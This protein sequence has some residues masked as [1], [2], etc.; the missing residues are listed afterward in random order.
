MKVSLCFD[1][2]GID[3]VR[4]ADVFRR[5]PLGIRDPEK[6][7]RAFEN[8][9]TVCFAFHKDR[10]MGMARALSDGEYHAAVY[11]LVVLPEYQG[12]GIGRKIVAAL[13][14]RLPVRTTILYAVPGKE[15]FYRKLGYAKM[16][17]AMARR[18]ENPGAFRDQ[19]YIE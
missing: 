19:G 6:L 3:W 1:T 10:L 8:S 4:A 2:E 13:H 9:G 14:R 17:T 16:L 5:A 18:A 12:Q 15:P 7:Q 11:D